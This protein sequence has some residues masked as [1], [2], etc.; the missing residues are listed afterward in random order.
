MNEGGAGVAAGTRRLLRRPL[1]R[2]LAWVLGGAATVL[3]TVTGVAYLQVQSAADTPITADSALSGGQSVQ[4]TPVSN[5]VR[6][7][8]GRAETIAGVELYR[9]AIAEPAES[10][11]LTVAFSWLDPQ[12]ADQ[13]LNSPNAWIG[14]GI[15]YNSGSAPSGGACPSGQYLLN[16]PTDGQVCVTADSGLDSSTALTAA[17]A[18]ALL[19]GSQSGRSVAY[20]VASINTTGHAPPGQQGNLTGLQYDIDVQ[21]H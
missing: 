9:I 5:T 20:I 14:V 1:R 8:N 7:T 21:I 6:I 13:V 12:D 11:H 4:V 17:R 16:D 18:D 10:A 3:L 19:L 2:R 15:Y